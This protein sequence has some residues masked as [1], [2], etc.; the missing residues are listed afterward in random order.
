MREEM[1]NVN[2]EIETVQKDKI[3]T[4]ELKNKISKILKNVAIWTSQQIEEVGRTGQWTGKQINRKKSNWRTQ[5]EEKIEKTNRAST[6][7]GTLPQ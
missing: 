7:C 5:K 2:R 4:L 3:E 6:T 1:E